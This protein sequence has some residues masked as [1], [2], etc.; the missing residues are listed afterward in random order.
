MTFSFKRQSL[1]LFCLAISTQAVA[2]QKTSYLMPADF[3]VPLAKGIQLRLWFNDQIN[4]Q[5]TKKSFF[6]G[7]Q[8][9]DTAPAICVTEEKTLI[10]THDRLS[11]EA[12]LRVALPADLRTDLKLPDGADSLLI[13]WQIDTHFPMESADHSVTVSAVD[14]NGQAVAALYGGS[15]SSDGS[16]MFYGGPA[17]GQEGSFLSG[18]A[19]RCSGE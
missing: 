4:K 13:R 6:G 18:R 9:S 11:E 1:L 19:L 2:W 3:I 10:N 14:V 8:E 12:S 17:L 5:V 7:L 16:D 15:I